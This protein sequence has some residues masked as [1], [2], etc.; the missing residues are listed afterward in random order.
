MN[1]LKIGIISLSVSITIAHANTEGV[2]NALT[3]SARFKHED[4]FAKDPIAG[5]RTSFSSV[6]IR[7]NLQ[8]NANSDLVFVLEPQFVKVF[9]AQAL[10]PT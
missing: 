9:G 6:R 1:F 3:G 5:D 7:P 8:I 4:T 2:S 10:L